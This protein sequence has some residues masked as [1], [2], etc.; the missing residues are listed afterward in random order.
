MLTQPGH[1]VPHF[2]KKWLA[3]FYEVYGV[4]DH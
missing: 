3:L 2:N 1:I 4:R